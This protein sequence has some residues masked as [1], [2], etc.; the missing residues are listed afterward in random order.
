MNIWFLVGTTQGSVNHLRGKAADWVECSVRKHPAVGQ[1][2]RKAGPA[3]TYLVF[4]HRLCVS[5]CGMSE[6]LC[7]KD[8]E[9]SNV[10]VLW[11]V[12]L[13]AMTET[14]R[15]RAPL[16]VHPAPHISEP[17]L[18]LNHP[19]PSWA[20]SSLLKPPLLLPARHFP[21]SFP[22]PPWAW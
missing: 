17:L 8:G 13:E 14:F 19:A 3:R 16:D 20:K 15:K 21:S 4:T 2:A 5:R 11:Q 10:W 1:R 18:D 7:E 6:W 9:E 12:P 22:D